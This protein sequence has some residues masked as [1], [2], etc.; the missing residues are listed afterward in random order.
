MK[1]VLPPEQVVREFAGCELGDPRRE[2]RLLEIVRKAAKDPSAS[3]PTMAG[4]QVNRVYEFLANEHIESEGILE[5]HFDQVRQRCSDEKEVY[6]LHDTSEFKFEGESRSGLGPIGGGRGFLGH[7]ALAASASGRPL[8]VL[9]FEPWVRPEEP[10]R[11]KQVGWNKRYRDP[12]KESARWPR[13]VETVEERLRDT[14]VSVVHVAD[15]EADDYAFIHTV[16]QPGRSF[17]IRIRADRTLASEDGEPGEKLFA[18][19]AKLQGL[20]TREV[21][22]SKRS[23]RGKSPRASRRH[24]A[25]LARSATLEFAATTIT[26]Q[27]PHA[28]G[29]D[30]PETQEVNVVR[31]FE[32]KPPDGETPVEW[33]LMTNKPVT[34]V[35]DVERVVDIYRARWLIEEYFKALKTGCMAE[36]RQLEDGHSLIN[37]TAVLVPIA[38][39]LLLLRF[40]ARTAPDTSCRAVISKT[41]Q[42]VLEVFADP[43][44]PKRAT[45]R[46]AL[47]AIAGMGGHLARNGEPGWLTLSRGLS[48]LLLLEVGWIAGKKSRTSR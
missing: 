43:P 26:L 40:T 41:Q 5:A 30:L 33:R 10:K 35:A 36:A 23:T 42:E 1:S 25:R 34:S 6:V 15:R 46:Q 31:V 2:A 44:L 9:G 11:G 8:G 45:V 20:M 3:L 4:K 18:T 37:T 32:A 39:L 17:V 47:H 21:P 24:P 29:R 48:R 38:Y 14:G 19:M 28:I 12:N 16:M 27:R 13:M 7:F 22:L